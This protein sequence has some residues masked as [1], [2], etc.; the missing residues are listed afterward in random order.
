MQTANDGE[1][2]IVIL[3]AVVIGLEN[4]AD[5]LTACMTS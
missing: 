1:L 3:E 2:P 4:S 5:Y